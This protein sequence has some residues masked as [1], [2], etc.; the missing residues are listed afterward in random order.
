MKRLR[1]VVVCWSAERDFFLN[2]NAGSL[3]ISWMWIVWDTAN[4]LAPPFPGKIGI[5]MS[6][7]W[8]EP[9]SESAEDK[10]AADR[11]LQFTVR[12]LL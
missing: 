7:N 1:Q 9:L 12:N 6:T 2:G 11:G 3:E 4:F 8:V 10:E 5:T